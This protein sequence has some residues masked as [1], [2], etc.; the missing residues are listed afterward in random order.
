MHHMAAAAE[1]IASGISALEARSR[2][3]EG[4]LWVKTARLERGQVASALL[5]KAANF[6]AAQPFMGSRP[7]Q[8]S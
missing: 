5:P 2:P 1:Q 4:V 6:V 7:S 8:N 3:A